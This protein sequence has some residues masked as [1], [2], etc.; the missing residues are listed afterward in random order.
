MKKIESWKDITVGQ[1][2]EI[3]KLNIENNADSI[4]TQSALIRILYGE[5]AENL[6]F[7]DY[8]DKVMEISNALNSPLKGEYKAEFELGGIEFKAKPI[9]EFSTREFT[10]FD[11]LARENNDEN[12]PMLLAL[13]YWGSDDVGYDN[14]HYVDC[15]RAK[16]EFLKDL[17]AVTAVGA[18]GFFTN[19][20]LAYLNNTILSSEA[21]RTMIESNPKMKEQMKVLRDFLDGVGTSPSMN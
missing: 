3:R 15:I 4:A 8:M 21:A 16:A 5:N 13:I 18:V 11:T 6:S 2:I 17:D 9:E 7:V 1:L 14:D 10:D 12:L 20:L 19:A